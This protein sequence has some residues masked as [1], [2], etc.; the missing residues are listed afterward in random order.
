ME[1]KLLLSTLCVLLLTTLGSGERFLVFFDSAESYTVLVGT[2]QAA[3]KEFLHKYPAL[4]GVAVE[5]DEIFAEKL[6]DDDRIILVERDGFVSLPDEL[7]DNLDTMNMV[8]SE[9]RDIQRDNDDS[10]DQESAAGGEPFR[11][12]DPLPIWSRKNPEELAK[13]FEKEWELE[14]VNEN[15]STRVIQANATWN[16]RR[17]GARRLPLPDLFVYPLASGNTTDIYIVD[18]GVMTTHAEFDERAMTGKSFVADEANTDLHGHGTHVA[19]IA[20]GRTLGVAKRASIIPVKVLNSLGS[21]SWS[22][23]IAGIDWC[24]FTSGF[25]GCLLTPGFSVILGFYHRLHCEE[26]RPL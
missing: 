26:G 21:G 2:I 10:D 6:K 11:Q 16:L 8:L 7:V 23:I 17:L 22:G 12:Q 24:V 18:T 25:A 15:P 13:D 1:L 4:N 14:N 19:G 5:C 20:A 9:M 3:S